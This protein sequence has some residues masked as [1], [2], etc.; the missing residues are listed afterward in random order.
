MSDCHETVKCSCGAVISNCRCFSPNKT[1]RIEQDGCNHCK[2]VKT[3]SK[4]IEVAT[5]AITI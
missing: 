1:I 2:A 5:P 3:A 4:I